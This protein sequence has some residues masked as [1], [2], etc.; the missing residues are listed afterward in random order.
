MSS[1][2]S[3]VVLG[4]GLSGLA[5]AWELARSGVE[6]TLVEKSA[7]LGGL[8]GSFTREGHVYPLG[9]HHILGR[10][11]VLLEFLD[12]I[13][14]LPSVRWRKIKML[15]RVREGL[16]DLGHPVDFLRFPMALSDKL[17]FARLMLGAFFKA[18][19][20]DWNERSARELIDGWAGPGVREAIFEPL[21]RLKFEL[22]CEE[23]SGAWLGARLHFREGSSAFGYIPGVNWTQV[24]CQGVEKLVREAGVRVVA[25]AELSRL[26]AQGGR[27][28]A[29]HT[30]DG[31]RLTAE[32][33]VSTIPTEVLTRLLPDE[34]DSLAGVRYSALLSVIC[35]TRQDLGREFYWMNLPTLDRAACGVFDLT[36]LNPTL[37]PRGERALNFVT[38]LNGRHRP[39]F[40]LSDEEL[41]ARYREDFAA[42]FGFPLEAK[43]WNV[44]RVAMY[45][46]VL[47]K[48][49]RN[50]PPRSPVHG[51][52]WFAGNYRTFPSIVSTGTALGSGVETARAVLAGGGA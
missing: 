45:S 50:P 25:P 29:A 19:W 21:T 47:I 11:R 15:F 24:L 9:Y 37:G 10:D 18:D 49:Y 13:G 17:R 8:A 3:A 31:Q 7:E 40:A 52:L 41:I 1:P 12:R 23:V 22:S 46:P 39:L 30:A 16:F 32:L 43:W 6:V 48:G 20:S 36:R 4:G 5:A 42:I 34:A 26:E 28:V 14:A 51:N 2:R 38:H 44:A 27:V 35:S 33:F